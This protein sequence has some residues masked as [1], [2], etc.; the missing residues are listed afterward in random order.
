M[1]ALIEL[2]SRTLYFWFKECLRSPFF[3]NLYSMI[4]TRLQM[5]AA[6]ITENPTMTKIE[7]SD[8]ET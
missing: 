3:S 8:D 7:Y 1:D 6:H 4:G 2:C 5:Y